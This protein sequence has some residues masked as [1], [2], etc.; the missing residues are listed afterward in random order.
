MGEEVS[1]TTEGSDAY[2][3]RNIWAVVFL[4][5]PQTGSNLKVLQ[6]GGFDLDCVVRFFPGLSVGN[7]A[8]QAAQTTTSGRC[9]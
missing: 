7:T 5:C 6:K 1:D 8:R 9:R 4:R 3:W 2:R